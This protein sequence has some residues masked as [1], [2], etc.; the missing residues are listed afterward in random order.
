[1]PATEAPP[2]AAPAAGPQP[3]ARWFATLYATAPLRPLLESLFGIEAEIYAVLRPGLEH[4]VAHVRMQWWQEECDR[5]AA[6]SGVHPLTRALLAARPAD[7]PPGVDL[8]G[9]M[10]TATWDLAAATFGARRELTGYCERWASAM[11]V[12]A[13]RW[14]AP[15]DMPADA[16]TALG[17]KL[18]TA[19]RELELL[20]ELRP[21]ALAGR[22]RLPLDELQAA[23]A[24]PE[25]LAQS[26]CPPALATLLR[27]RH[28]Q[29]QAQLRGVLE[30]I[31]DPAQRTAF[32]GLIVW[33]RLALRQS[34]L[35]AAAL[36]ARWRPTRAS[37]LGDAWHAWRYARRSAIPSA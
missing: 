3:S 8:R 26:P 20:L 35:L 32:R 17:G 21:A 5:A 13:V 16:A 19:L 15:A 25:A 24:D 22:L 18:G 12:P 14:A 10:D 36:P 37:G 9:L 2:G 29:A 23:G 1:M 6:G 33:A 27:E 30:G 34:A 28:R 4:S 7:A 11:T 31:T